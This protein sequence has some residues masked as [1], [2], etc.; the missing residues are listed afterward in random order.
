LAANAKVIMSQHYDYIILGTG[1]AGFSLAYRMSQNAF[2][3]NKKILLLDQNIKAANDRTWSFWE[4]G[5]GIFEKIVH[6]KWQTCIYTDGVLK[7]HKT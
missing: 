4:K 5:D 1:C 2:F 6:H 3:A 7:Q